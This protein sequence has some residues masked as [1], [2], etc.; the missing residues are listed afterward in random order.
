M[1]LQTTLPPPKLTPQKKT[2]TNPFK[3]SEPPPIPLTST[4]STLP[5]P[6]PLLS[7]N[8]PL[9]RLLTLKGV[10]NSRLSYCLNFLTYLKELPLVKW[11]ADGKIQSPFQ[12]FNII[13]FVDD[14]SKIKGTIPKST[15]IHYINFIKGTGLDASFIKN[16]DLKLG[17]NSGKTG[18]AVGQW[19]AWV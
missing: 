2:S 15:F 5:P 17:L 1:P 19:R 14:A 11:D 8:P 16:Q 9:L 4:H 3:R 6:S 18:G 12:G 7:A 10:P 13:D